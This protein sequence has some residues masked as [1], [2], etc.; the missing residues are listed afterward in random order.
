MNYVLDACAM[1]ALAA[2]Q[3]LRA[4]YRLQRKRNVGE[5]GKVI[6]RDDI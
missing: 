3:M 4:H 1:T 6:D 5:C 2:F